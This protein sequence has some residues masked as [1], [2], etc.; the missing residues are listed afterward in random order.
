MFSSLSMLSSAYLQ[1]CNTSKL[2]EILLL[3]AVLLSRSNSDSVNRTVR[4]VFAFF[5]SLSTL[6]IIITQ[7]NIMLIFGCIYITIYGCIL[8]FSVI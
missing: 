8:L 7:Y 5:S 4:G 3:V 6:N 1:H 2:N